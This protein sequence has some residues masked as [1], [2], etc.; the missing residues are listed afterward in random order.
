LGDVVDVLLDEGVDER[1]LHELPNHEM[2]IDRLPGVQLPRFYQLAELLV[3]LL[4]ALQ[5]THHA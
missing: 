1:R 5:E 3:E 4:L 2:F